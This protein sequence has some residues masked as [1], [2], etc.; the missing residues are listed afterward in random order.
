MAVPSAPIAMRPR[1]TDSGIEFCWGASGPDVTHYTLSC[2]ELSYSSDHIV[3]HAYV[4]WG[5]FPKGSKYTF[6]VVAHSSSGS[7]EPGI[8][9]MISH[10]TRSAPVEG[11]HA[12]D[13]GDGTA[14]VSWL[15]PSAMAVPAVEW[16]VVELSSGSKVPL[17]FSQLPSLRFLLINGL[18][19]G[20]DA[21]AVDSTAT[22]FAVN[23]AGYSLGASV[24][25]VRL[26]LLVRDG[27]RLCLHAAAY[28][29]HGV[30]RDTCRAGGD[31]TVETGVGA[32][33]RG[34][35]VVLDGATNWRIPPVGPLVAWTLSI[36]FKRT[37]ASH[38]Q[39][40]LFTEVL[41]GGVLQLCVKA[42]EDGTG[43]FQVG[44]YDGAFHLGNPVALPVGEWNCVT[45]T[46]D[47][48][49]LTTYL[50]ATQMSVI[51]AF[52]H[53][54]ISA[55]TYYKLGCRWDA[56]EY[57]T[58]EVGEVLLYDRVLT[59]EERGVNWAATR[60]TLAD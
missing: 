26:P 59:E 55:H 50:D 38:G 23:D 33:V 46:W 34:G 25:V 60:E 57:V 48:S 49:L 10:G 9:C 27:L 4:L 41:G 17:R 15:P 35:G 5:D 56:P 28:A 45:A 16:Y 21:K 36:W 1:V 30:W 18:V 47:G 51:D 22:V 54:S 19:A 7:S 58:G 20:A 53:A 3:T 14:H 2:A 12:V 31:A 11:V 24:K 44:F 42:A 43:R 8:V 13:H 52:P 37:G 6:Q 39:A 29:G 32:R 40:C